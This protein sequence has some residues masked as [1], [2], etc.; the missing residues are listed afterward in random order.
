[1]PSVAVRTWRRDELYDL[2]LAEVFNL[3]DVVVDRGVVDR[4]PASDC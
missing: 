3:V 1:M 2:S 4:E